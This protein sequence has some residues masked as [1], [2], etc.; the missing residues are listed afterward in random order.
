MQQL[1]GADFDALNFDE[2]KP[3]KIT[4][5][6]SFKLEKKKMRSVDTVKQLQQ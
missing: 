6:R 1:G 4:K 2:T 5:Y 3:R